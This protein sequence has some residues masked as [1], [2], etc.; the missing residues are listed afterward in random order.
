MKIKINPD[1]N[2]SGFPVEIKELKEDGLSDEPIKFASYTELDKFTHRQ[3]GYICEVV[4]RSKDGKRKRKYIISSPSFQHGRKENSVYYIITK[5]KHKQ[6]TNMDDVRAFYMSHPSYQAGYAK[7]TGRPKKSREQ[8][9]LEKERRRHLLR[10][11][12]TKYGDIDKAEGSP[13]LEELRK[14]IGA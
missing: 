6:V 12:D 5:V 10:E 11:I 9:L 4:K 7:Y 2:R 3:S 1:K 14:L 13:E 8:L